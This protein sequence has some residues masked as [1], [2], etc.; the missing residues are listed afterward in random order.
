MRANK[1]PK[2]KIDSFNISTG[3]QLAGKYQVAGK[4]GEGWEGEVYKV[5]EMS[6]G[7]ERAAKV[8][9]PHRNPGNRAAKA[10]AL[11]LHK[12]R[13]C[14]LLIQY[15]TKEIFFYRRLPVTVLISEF[16]EGAPLSE[17][18]RSLPGKRLSPYP[19]LHLLYA[20]TR[21]IEEIH[22]LNEYHGDIHT[23]NIIVNGFGLKFDLKLL[24]FYQHPAPKAVNI[25]DDLCGLIHVFHE[26]LGGSKRYKKHP[27]IVKEICCGLKRSLILKKFKSVSH[28]RDF[29]ETL[30][31]VA[32]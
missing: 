28:L 21:G 19:A 29:L 11:K 32:V 13:Q 1:S 5:V 15:H 30:Q 12:L 3:R 22:L 6:T 7:I 23:D 14:S 31:W 9:F 20:L 8:F 27:P 18:L 2:L 4:L 17:F 25:R 26:C 10:Y 16:V 24:D